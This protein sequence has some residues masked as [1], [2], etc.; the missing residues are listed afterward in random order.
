[1]QTTHAHI[2]SAHT[3][4]THSTHSARTRRTDRALSIHPALGSSDMREPNRRPNSCRNFSGFGVCTGLLTALLLSDSAGLFGVTGGG[5]T[6]AGAMSIERAASACGKWLSGGREVARSMHLASHT[7]LVHAAEHGGTHRLTGPCTRLRDHM[8]DGR[9]KRCGFRVRFSVSDRIRF[10]RER[11][12]HIGIRFDE[13]RA[14]GRSRLN[15][16]RVKGQRQ[17]SAR[18]QQRA[19]STHWPVE[20]FSTCA[21]HKWAN[22]GGCTGLVRAGDTAGAV[23]RGEGPYV[24]C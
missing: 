18:Q 6:G 4:H 21:A 7:P 24:L 10:G 23:A 22:G 15:C 17:H 14:P 5:L 12:L 8:R 3:Q 13:R 11:A 2:H 9:S 20:V 19:N 16:L 1:V